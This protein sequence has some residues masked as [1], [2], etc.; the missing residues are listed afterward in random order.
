MRVCTFFQSTATQRCTKKVVVSKYCYYSFR[1][2]SVN[3][4]FQ[5]KTT[6]CRRRWRTW[7]PCFSPE[8]HLLS[9]Y[10]EVAISVAVST[11]CYHY[12]YCCRKV[13]HDTCI[14]M[15]I[16]T[17]L[18]FTPGRRGVRGRPWKGL[19]EMGTAWWCSSFTRSARLARLRLSI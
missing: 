11:L 17:H 5:Q 10:R 18:L 4:G 1:Q 8:K 3:F 19:R 14:V 9:A 13:Q 6:N 15:V 12:Q 16:L 2:T 7:T